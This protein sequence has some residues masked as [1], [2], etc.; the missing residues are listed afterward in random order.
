M[1]LEQSA[2]RR[3]FVVIHPLDDVQ[4]QKLETK[5]LRPLRMTLAVRLSLLALRGYLAL[6]MLLVLYH[7]L[8]LAGFLGKA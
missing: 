6:M 2:D 8:D 1:I 5:H 4:E 7:V 3:H